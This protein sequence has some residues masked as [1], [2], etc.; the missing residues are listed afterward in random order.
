MWLCVQEAL[1]PVSPAADAASSTAECAGKAVQQLIAHPAAL[2]LL[3]A[4]KVSQ[5]GTHLHNSDM[6]WCVGELRCTHL[7]AGDALLCVLLSS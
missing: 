2:Q 1:S 4:V 7:A 3:Q 5:V 6:A